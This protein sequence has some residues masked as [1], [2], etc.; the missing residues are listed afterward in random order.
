VAK[1]F[2]KVSVDVR[3]DR[4]LALVGANRQL[5]VDLAAHTGAA[6]HGN[7]QAKSYGSR[8]SGIVSVMVFSFCDSNIPIL[9]SSLQNA[10]T[11]CIDFALILTASLRQPKMLRLLEI[12]LNSFSRPMV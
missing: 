1:V 4:L 2:G 5:G 12:A 7:Q 6:G 3:V 11:I 10:S 9:S 8:P